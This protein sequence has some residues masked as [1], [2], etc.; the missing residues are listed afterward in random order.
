M[1][2][3]KT[4]YPEL[5]AE[6]ID[7]RA[8][9]LLREFREETNR[10]QL[11]VP[12]EVIAEQYL[13]YEIEIL[14]D[15]LFSDP[16]Y[17][18]GIIFDKNLIQVNAAVERHEGRYSFTLAHE[19]GHHV[20]HRDIYL[21]QKDVDT[22]GGMCRET[23]EKPVIEKQA[24]RFAAALLMPSTAVADVID[25]MDD[26]VDTKSV[27][28][29]RMIASRV[30]EQGNFTNVSNSAMVNRLIDLGYAPDAIYQTGTAHDFSRRVGS[31]PWW[32]W[33]SFWKL[34]QRK[35]RRKK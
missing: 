2:T 25:A 28:G 6:T 27:A 16:D 1:S 30:I 19:I 9:Q 17:L 11:P 13:G 33:N 32:L 26:N 24:D 21:K 10:N 8:D 20:L 35:R 34:F 14:D 18:G 22:D 23:G 3:E 7:S 31:T 4:I 15:G 5:S 12:V 29:M